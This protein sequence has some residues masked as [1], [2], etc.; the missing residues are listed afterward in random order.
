MRSRIFLDESELPPKPDPE[1]G[2]PRPPRAPIYRGFDEKS[3]EQLR[4]ERV[5]DPAKAP[6][7]PEGQG[8]L[9]AWYRA[10]RKEALKTAAWGLLILPV[11]VTMTRLSLDWA[12]FWQAWIFVPLTML[13]VYSTQRTVVVSAG[14]EWLK[15]GKSWV[16]LYELTDIDA[17]HRGN[18]MHVDLTDDAGR[19]VKCKLI[20]LQKDQHLWDLVYNG[21]LH[22][23]IAG[24]AT[25]TGMVH[26][27]LE[28]PR[29][30]GSVT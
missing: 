13:A 12:Q 21:I 30:P 28:V 29:R 1:T 2:E 26:S 22:S 17:K 24:G 6:A 9:L 19:T 7:P 8:P 11:L 5:T 27:A 23:V 18:D 3:E 14:A 15:H 4:R 10:S 25:T 16:R 20:D